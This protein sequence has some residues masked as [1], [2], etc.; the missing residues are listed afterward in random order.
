MTLWVLCLVLATGLSAGTPGSTFTIAVA[1][2]D[3]TDD[4]GA[5]VVTDIYPTWGTPCDGAQFI[6]HR[7]DAQVSHP[8]QVLSYTRSFEIPD[9]VN[10]NKGQFHLS[11]K[12]DDNIRISINDVVVADCT[13]AVC[14]FSDEIG[15]IRSVSP[16]KNVFQTG[17]NVMNVVIRDNPDFGVFIMGSYALVMTFEGAAPTPT[18]AQTPTPIP[19]PTPIPTITPMP[20]LTP[21]VSCSDTCDRALDIALGSIANQNVNCLLQSSA[22]CGV[23]CLLVPGYL[24]C[25]APCLVRGSLACV[26]SA[27]VKSAI[28]YLA[29]EYCLHLCD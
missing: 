29:W 12:A 9:Y 1:S 10:I 25:L 15:C 26:H 8:G 6:S 20:T 11:Y 4:S 5:V 22:I 3:D 14:F 19:S 16:N 2:G 23:S 7:H 28:A 17:T 27:S 24:T 18:P 21:E 13:E